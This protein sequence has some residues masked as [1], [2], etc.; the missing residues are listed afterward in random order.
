MTPGEIKCDIWNSRDPLNLQSSGVGIKYRDET[1]N[2]VNHTPLL[3]MRYFHHVGRVTY[4]SIFYPF[5]LG[6]EHAANNV[7]KILLPSF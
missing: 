1:K 2:N 5:R 7:Q 3:C 6:V 4:V